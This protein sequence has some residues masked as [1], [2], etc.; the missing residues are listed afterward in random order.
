RFR[1]WIWVRLKVS[2]IRSA[3]GVRRQAKRDAALDRSRGERWYPKRRRASLAAALHIKPIIATGPWT[4]D[5]GPWTFDL[6]FARSAPAR[7]Q[8][9]KKQTSRIATPAGSCHDEAIS[10]T[11]F[12][13]ATATNKSV[14]P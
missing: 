4:P 9:P 7:A 6:R 10:F 13:D 1:F 14:R 8:R 11:P 3:C 5:F 2:V 12:R